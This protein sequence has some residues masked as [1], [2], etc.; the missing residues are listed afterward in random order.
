M[1]KEILDANP[2]HLPVLVQQLKRLDGEANRKKHLDKVIAGADTV[3]AQIDT[4]TLAKHY[5]VK[6]KPDDEEAK[7]ERAKLDKKL[8]TLTDA[9]YRKGRALGYLD[10]QL[11]E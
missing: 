10:T 3:I 2:N 5:G 9:L 1:A 8:N 11:R 4:E 7:A 6:L